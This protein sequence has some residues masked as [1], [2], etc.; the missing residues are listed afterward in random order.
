MERQLVCSLN[1]LFEERKTSGAN[2]V[3]AYCK[4]TANLTLDTFQCIYTEVAVDTIG[5]AF[6]L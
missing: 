3:H 6:A 5:F 2:Q 1:Y 4:V